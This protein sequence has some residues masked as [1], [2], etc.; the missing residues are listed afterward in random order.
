MSDIYLKADRSGFLYD[1]GVRFGPFGNPVVREFIPAKSLS[2]SGITLAAHGT[3]GKFQYVTVAPLG[4]GDAVEYVWPLPVNQDR[5]NRIYVAALLIANATLSNNVTLKFKYSK[6]KAGSDV[7]GAASTEVDQQIN[8]ISSVT[9]DL[10]FWTDWGW[11]DPKSTD[12]FD[13]LHL[14]MDA[15]LADAVNDADK[16]RIIGISIAYVNIDNVR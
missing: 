6:L 8:V 16:V 14:R 7:A 12:D 3:T 1:N 2:L 13:L 5:R 15:T 4:D 10:P 9:A 11:I